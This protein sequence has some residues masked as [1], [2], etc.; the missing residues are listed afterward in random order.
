MRHGGEEERRG[1]VADT[2]L[3]VGIQTRQRNHP[4]TA[5]GDIKR[6]NSGPNLCR[7]ACLMASLH[8]VGSARVHG[9]ARLP[10]TPQTAF[11]LHR[12]ITQRTGPRVSRLNAPIVDGG[13]R[14]R[15]ESESERERER[16]RADG[17]EHRLQMIW[18]LRPLGE[19]GKDEGDADGDSTPQEFPSRSLRRDFRSRLHRGVPRPELARS[20]RSDGT[21][22]P[23]CVTTGDESKMNRRRK[24]R[25]PRAISTEN[26]AGEFTLAYL[27]APLHHRANHRPAGD[28]LARH[29]ARL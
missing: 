9:A 15:L 19:K 22:F 11:R 23:Y 6:G 12:R 13:E 1:T 21:L 29:P 27:M 7:C 17:F 20:F 24:S 4:R 16:E 14:E 26:F 2:E 10:E 3:G 5:A 28:E 8:H 18:K 25:R